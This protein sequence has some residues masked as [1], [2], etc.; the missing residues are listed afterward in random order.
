MTS[1]YRCRRHLTHTLF[2][3]A[4]LLLTACSTVNQ[5]GVSQSDF[6]ALNE[7]VQYLEDMIAIRK[8]QATYIHSLFTQRF[9]DI[10]PL[11]SRRPDVSVEFS[12]S[13]VY[14]GH[15]RISELYHTFEATKDLPGFFIMHMSTNPYIE[16]AADGLSAR[17][18]WLSPGASHNDGRSSWIWG[19]YYVNY[20]KENG[21]WRILRS[22]LVPVFRNP[23]EYSW[24]D[25]PNH[26]TVRVL[27]LE[28]DEPTTLYRPFDEVRDETD[29]FS[30]HPDLPDPYET[31][32]SE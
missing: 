20:V 3:L 13:G 26:G 12:D 9:T 18:H 28:P 24:G 15:D 32:G 29:I 2:A 21:E 30:E 31:L 7:R 16:I 5:S 19:P 8:L 25:A 1:L 23:Y 17:S 14:R 27:G 11:F 22:N 6:N 10:P 4:A